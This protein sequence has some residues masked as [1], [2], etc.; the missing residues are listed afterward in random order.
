MTPIADSECVDLD[1]IDLGT[2]GASARREAERRRDGRSW[3]IGAKGEEL[4]AA[5]LAKRCPNAIVLHDR[6]V[7]RSR[8]N[9][10]H[11][12]IAP[13]GVWVIDPKRYTGKIAVEK[14]FFGEPKLRIKG[15]DRSKLIEGLSRQVT[16]V[17]EA[18]LEIAPH[19]PVTGCLCFMSPEGFL[20]EAQL[21]LVR[22]LIMNG[23]PLLYPKR[24][25]TRLNA[26]GDLIPE[27]VHAIA[28]Q[29][30]EHFPAKR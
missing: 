13:S 1:G 2:P 6:C 22:T 29:L 8:A 28:A 18:M 12:A 10:D 24:V 9:I 26:P 5:S 16:L 20:A 21:P 3:A 14:P 4:M 11:I 19:V 23:Y 30:A 27:Q 25:A 17:R 7:P 15:R